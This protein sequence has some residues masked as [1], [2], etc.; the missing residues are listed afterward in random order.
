[1]SLAW[2]SIVLLVALLPGVLFFVGMYLPEKFSRDS[3][4]RSALGHLAGVLLVSLFVHGTLYLLAP[5]A[6][7]R[8]IPC[9]DLELFL[10]LLTLEQWKGA[11]LDAVR[12]VSEN[13]WWIAAYLAATSAGGTGI[14]YAVGRAAVAGRA[15]WLTQHRWAYKLSVGDKLTTAWVMTHVR[16]GNRVLIYRGFLHAFHLKRDG[17]FSYVVLEH[18]RRGYLALRDD[19]AHTTGHWTS[20]GQSPTVLEAG[21]VLKRH[22]ATLFAIEGE[23]I[24]NIVFDRFEVG[25]STS[26][27]GAALEKAFESAL[28][29]FAASLKESSNNRSAARG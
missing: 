8:L 14:G 26:I 22:D 3:V 9:P 18:V 7:G 13:R 2:G 5:I 1:M 21:D 16:E 17:T 11:G 20:I 28:Q 4:E 12:T 25:F 6:C 10:R 29:H 27:T 15:P 24:A 19:G 23:D